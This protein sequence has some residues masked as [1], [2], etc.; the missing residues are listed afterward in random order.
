MGMLLLEC[1]LFLMVCITGLPLF[2]FGGSYG[3]VWDPLFLARLFPFFSMFHTLCVF[4]IG[5]PT[6]V[7]QS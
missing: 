5:L 2:L 6:A 1:P 7:F 3:L 4:P